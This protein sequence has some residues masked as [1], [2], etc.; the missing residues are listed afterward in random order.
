MIANFKLWAGIFWYDISSIPD[1]TVIPLF[2][3]NINKLTFKKLNWAPSTAWNLSEF[4]LG[5]VGHP[6]HTTVTILSELSR[7]WT[8][9]SF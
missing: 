7:L 6:P 5:Y 3:Q 9:I 1:S 2:L 4:K 8:A